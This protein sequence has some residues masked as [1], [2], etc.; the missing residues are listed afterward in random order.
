MRCGGV[1]AGG[2]GPDLHRRADPSVYRARPRR[3]SSSSSPLVLPGRP[4]GRPRRPRARQPA[5]AGDAA[6]RARAAA[7]TGANLLI[8]R[9]RGGDRVDRAHPRRARRLA[10]VRVDG[11]AVDRLRAPRRLRLR[12]AAA[13]RA[14]ARHL[15]R[16]APQRLR[17]LALD[18]ARPQRG[19]RPARVAYRGPRSRGAIIGFLGGVV[20]LILGSL[21]MPALLKLAGV[22][23]RAG[24]G[25]E[26]DRRLLGRRRRRDRPP[27]V[28][29][30]RTGRVA[31]V[32]AAASIPG[33]LL[34]SRLTGRLAE[35]QLVRAIAAV[36]VVAGSPPRCRRSRSLSGCPPTRSRRRPTSSSAWCAST[37]STR[38]ATSA[39][40]R[41]TSPA[42]CATPASRSSCSGAPS[43]ARTSSRACAAPATARRCACS[44]TSTPSWPTP[45]EWQHDPWS[46]DVVDGELWGRGALDMK[47]QTAAEV[48]AAI[49]ARA[50]GLAPA[51]G[52]LL[53]VVVVDEETGG[54]EGA[55]WICEEHPDKVRCD[56][57]LNEGAGHRVPVRR[58][59]PL[60]RLRR[61][62]GRLPLQAAHARRRRPRVD[63]EDRRQ[64][65]AEARA[66]AARRWATASR[67][68]TSPRR[69]GGCSR[70]SACRSTATRPRRS[71]SCAS[72]TRSSAL[73]VEPMLGVTL[74][75][76]QISAS[77]KINVIP[78]RGRDRRRLPRP[79]GAGRGARAERIREVLGDE[80]LRDR[81][82]REGHR[83][84]LAGRRRR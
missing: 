18:A 62:E 9:G 22:R 21:R 6:R 49:D 43:R 23:A 61:R 51:T 14:A 59:A 7:G 81:V 17:A 75:P 60:R 2:R 12:R 45:S 74:A 73:L 82:L 35:P 5:P 47:S 38:R 65:A 39:R 33:A 8:A 48:V 28:R 72:A 69:R 64:R 16:P 30:A 32:G 50:L 70:R 71:T 36:L 10:A 79:A 83:Q 66:A 56:Y 77:E 58:R 20:G 34:G 29:D 11:A 3:W 19:R 84:P 25:H 80:R 55:Q 54:D 1:R 67:P 40:R 31:A 44:A 37:P 78:S 76:T 41:S 15:R 27:A 52:D 68:S 46:G 63:A 13:H 42:C 26:R 4:R 24:G 57:L 53:V